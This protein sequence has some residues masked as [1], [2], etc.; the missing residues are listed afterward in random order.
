[1]LCFVQY[2]GIIDRDISR[3]YS[4]II[5]QTDGKLISPVQFKS[6]GHYEGT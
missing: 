4:I 3:A 5:W 6:M 2:R 1:M